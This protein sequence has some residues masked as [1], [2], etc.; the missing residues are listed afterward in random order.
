MDG[1]TVLVDYQCEGDVAT[2]SLNRPEKL[3]AVSDDLIEALARALKRFDLD[4]DAKVGILC[5]RGRAFCSGADVRQRQMRSREQ[6]ATEGG[7]GAGGTSPIDLFSSRVNAKPIIAAPHGFA[8]GLGF[9]LVLRSDMVVAEAGTQ[10]QVTEIGR[11]ISGVRFWA[12]MKMLGV[13]V[14]AEEVCLTGRFFTAE[15]ACA[16]GM[17]R[18][19]APK[20]QH[21]A[22]ALE[23]ARAIAANP[24]LSVREIVRARRYRADNFEREVLY[25]SEMSKLYL[26]EDFQEAVRAFAEKRP[27]KPFKGR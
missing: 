24:P 27:P 9:G 6:L 3:N 16:E 2:I 14:F 7:P 15:E 17:I 25:G 12:Q 5:G 19:V 1:E 11:G 26:T 22:K 13:G 18:Y 4:P 21:M 8:V 10:F 23:Y 20:G